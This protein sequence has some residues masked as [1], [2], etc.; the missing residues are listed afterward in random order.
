MFFLKKN[1]NMKKQSDSKQKTRPHHVCTTWTAY[2]HGES[3]HEWVLYVM[4]WTHTRPCP[5]NDIHVMSN[6]KNRATIVLL[7][8]III[9]QLLIHD[10]IYITIMCSIWKF[11]CKNIIG[12]MAWQCM[13]SWEPHKRVQN[14]NKPRTCS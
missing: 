8:Y 3:I 10:I 2:A 9:Y 12:Y 14:W 1:I 7:L 13:V 4:L 5:M 6:Y 11:I